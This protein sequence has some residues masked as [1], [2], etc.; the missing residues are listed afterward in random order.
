LL[1]AYDLQAGEWS[2][3]RFRVTEQ[4]KPSAGWTIK[5][6]WISDA[7]GKPVRVSGEDLGSFNGQFSR[8]EGDEVT[9]VHHWD[10]WSDEPAWKLRAHFEHP[11]KPGCW[12]EYLVR[13]EFLSSPASDR[14]R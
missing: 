2:E 10:F 1:A 3:L 13:P 9:C 4:G 11:A 5:E 8:N 12:V 6:M 7:I 14:P